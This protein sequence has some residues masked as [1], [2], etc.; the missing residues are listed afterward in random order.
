MK[1]Y[2]AFLR[3]INVAGHSL[4]RMNDLRE[5]FVRAGCQAVRTYIQSGNVVF[6]SSEREIVSVVQ[7]IENELRKLLGAQPR[8]FLRTIGEMEK[9]IRDAPF[10]KYEGKPDIGLYVTFLFEKPRARLKLPF[11]SSKEAL[12][13][14]AIKGLEVF[15]V[16]RR[17]KDG[18]HGFPNKFLEQELG[19][20][21]TTR[22]IS[23]VTKI[24]AFAR[25]VSGG[26]A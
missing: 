13:V 21:A 17:K 16:S 23:T 18:T 4:V 20:P 10:K 14:L 22:N 19:V 2:V 26:E 7:K 5:A 8:L 1:Q 3:A 24:V 25:G 12:E 6:E 11:V 15:V 9:I